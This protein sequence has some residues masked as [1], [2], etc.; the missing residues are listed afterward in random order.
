M[1]ILVLYV[2]MTEKEKQRLTT[3][4]SWR[5]TGIVKVGKTTWKP[6]HR[7]WM[8]AWVMWLSGDSG[9]SRWEAPLNVEAMVMDTSAKEKAV[10]II[11]WIQ[12]LGQFLFW[13]E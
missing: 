6:A 4:L 11:R 1:K 7:V 9:M 12:G 8:L 10:K 5:E 2:V 3:I 13:E